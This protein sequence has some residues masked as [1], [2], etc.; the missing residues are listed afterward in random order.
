MKSNI[1][2]ISGI[3]KGRLIPFNQ[4]KYNDADITPQKVKGALF[5]MIGERLHMK[6]F[7]DLYSGSGQI[8][9]EAISRESQLVVFNEK[10]RQRFDFIK[11]FIVENGLEERVLLLNLNAKSALRNMEERGVRA[12]FI[13]A[14]PPY[15]KEKGKTDFYNP[16]LEDIMGSGILTDNSEIIIQHFS[17][18]VLPE[19]C[20][21]L[22]KTGTR[23]YG[24][25]SLSIYSL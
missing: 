16:V 5:S 14:D 25:T 13:F 23:K 1:R 21:D 4:A 15:E 2:I 6:T 22:K 10:D 17:A 20:G 19:S 11:K 3:M 12:D 7:V 9:F 8:G 18:N 24:T